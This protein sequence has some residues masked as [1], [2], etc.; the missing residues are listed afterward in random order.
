MTQAFEIPFSSPPESF[1]VTIAGVAYQLT[2]TWNDQAGCWQLAIADQGGTP[3]L[4]GIPLVTGANLLEQYDYL[5]LGFEL[6]VQS[7]T[8]TDAVPGFGD[9]GNTGHLYAILP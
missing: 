4:A 1:G 7:D 9:L 5:G 8:Q 2:A 3:I 6:Q